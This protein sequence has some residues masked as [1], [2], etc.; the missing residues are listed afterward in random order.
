MSVPRR[1]FIA[2]TDTEIGKTFATCALLHRARAD[3]L[4]AIGMKPVAAG[5]VSPDGPL[6]N[7]DA[8]ALAAASGL[9]LPYDWINPICLREAIAPHIAAERAGQAIA[10]DTLLDGA[11]R[12][13]ARC[14]LLLIEGV[15]GFRVPLGPDYDTAML[16][17]DLAAPVVL[18]V[19]MRLGCINHA[20]LTAEAIHARGLRLAGWIANR[21][22]GAMPCFE[23]N[24]AALRA[25]LDAPLLGVLPHQPDRNPAAVAAHLTLPT[26]PAE[27][28]HAAIAILDSA[29]ELGAA[30]RGRVVVTG[31]HGGVSAA[32]YALEARPFLCFFNDAGEG[33]DGAGI[34]ALAL[35]EA[36]GL[37]AACYGHL[38]ARI[39]DARD[40]F[41]NGRIQQV[42][43]LAE[44]I[45]VLPGMSVVEAASHVSAVRARAGSD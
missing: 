25:R 37:A 43:G 19:G 11:D 2:G 45:G 30:H 16:A 1:L 26:E 6:H 15:G 39:G 42:N 33:K 28:R 41:G 18:V 35:L 27:R 8:L 32:R 14:D 5:T 9:D 4:R 44:S 13:A 21:V 12:L 17:R 24:V 23:E 20:L 36:E 38:S 40:A 3:G 22:S 34:A 31:S 7:E 29:A 10:R